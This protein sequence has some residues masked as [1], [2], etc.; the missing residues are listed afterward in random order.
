MGKSLQKITADVKA[1]SG[2]S[3]WQRINLKMGIFWYILG[4]FKL[5]FYLDIRK[6]I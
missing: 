6:Y 1:T 4:E 2:K 5:N 3:K